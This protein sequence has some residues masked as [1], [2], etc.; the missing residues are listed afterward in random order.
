MSTKLEGG[1][2]LRKPAITD[3]VKQFVEDMAAN[4]DIIDAL[5]PPGTIRITT[6]PTNP[7][8]YLGG[9]WER[10]AGRFIVGADDSAYKPGTTGGRYD[11]GMHRNSAESEAGAEAK[12]A[13]LVKNTAAANCMG[14]GGRVMVAEDGYT[15]RLEPPFYAAYIWRRVS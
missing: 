13:G 15:G 5:F 4:I 10:I 2:G 9:S 12:D 1:L 3:T 11:M 8:D 7:G 14:F 6:S